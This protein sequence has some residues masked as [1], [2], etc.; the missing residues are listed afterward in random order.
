MKGSNFSPFSAPEVGIHLGNIQLSRFCPPLN[1]T[2]PELHRKQRGGF[3]SHPGF[4]VEIINLRLFCS[5]ILK[6]ML[7]SHLNNFKQDTGKH[8]QQVGA[9]FGTTTGRPRR[10]GWLDLVVVRYT[11]MVNGYTA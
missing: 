1:L 10:C 7:R 9:E 11:H 5:A 2:D 3:E 4:I 8:L 6:D